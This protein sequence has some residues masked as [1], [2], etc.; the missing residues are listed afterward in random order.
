MNGHHPGGWGRRNGSGSWIV[1]H[2][3]DSNG[4][5]N[6]VCRCGAYPP[7]QP[8]MIYFPDDESLAL[9]FRECFRCKD[10]IGAGG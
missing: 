4:K 6:M 1:H 10:S 2:F 5:G 3:R 9:S 7:L 8:A